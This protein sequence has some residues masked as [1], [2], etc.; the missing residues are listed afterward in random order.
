MVIP[1]R[2]AFPLPDSISLEAGAIIGCAVSTAYH[3]VSYGGLQK[4][5]TVVVFGM[6]GVGMHVI[7]WARL[8]GA[9]LVI[10]V[11]VIES[12]LQTATSFGADVV[13]HGRR[14]DVAVRVAAL[15]DG[16]G[17]DMALE[18]S[19]SPESMR[20]AV[21]CLHGKSVYESGRLVGV[22]AFMDEV[23]MDQAWLFREGAFLRSGDHTRRD[24]R[25]VIRLAG[26]GRIDLEPSITHRFNF[27]DLE[28]V[29]ATLEARGENIIR[30]VLV[31]P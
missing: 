31:L 13:L 10:G 16:F 23:I 30:A 12:K 15:T 3:A 5:D 2:N 18:C 27:G 8:W 11:D 17:A 29:L 1:A 9:G 20:M 28:H 21:K 19:G 7:R 22:A 4:G 6:G 24:L 25:E 26:T 14:D